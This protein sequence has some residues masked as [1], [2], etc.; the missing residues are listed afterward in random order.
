LGNS[1]DAFLDGHCEYYFVAVL[2]L[3]ALAVRSFGLDLSFGRE[4][5]K[6]SC[7]KF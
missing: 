5:K 2:V 7:I 4:G 6:T 1:V 3:M